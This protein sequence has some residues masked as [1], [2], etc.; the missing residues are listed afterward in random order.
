MERTLGLIAGAGALPALIGAR[1]RAQGWRI[2]AFTFAGCDDLGTLPHR[3]IPS[4]VAAA[5]TVLGG[6]TS[7]RVT[8]AVLCGRFS[9]P[10]VLQAETL[11]DTSR[12]M[13]A[14][15]GSRVDV[16]LVEAVIATFAALGVEVLDQRVFVGDLIAGVGCWSRRP[17]TDDERVMIQRGLALARVMA[18]HHVGQTVVLRHGA[19]TAVEAAEGTTAAIRRGATLGG[20]GAVIVKA[21]ARDHDYRVDTPAIGPETIAAAAAGGAAALAIEAGRVMILDRETT[22]RA[23]D[24][25]GMALVGVDDAG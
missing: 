5:A 1:A 3:T 6:L 21:V 20:P 15:A 7:E 11:D 8:A 4:R 18:D 24:Q 17:P 2:V 10:D 19:V 25:A 16:K 23:A 14:L 13:D 12:A 22:V 9:M